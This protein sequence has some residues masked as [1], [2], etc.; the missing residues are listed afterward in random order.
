[1]LTGRG[2]FALVL[3]VGTYV[4][5]WAFGSDALYP[6]AIGLVLVALTAGVWVRLGG[7]P[8]SIKRTVEGGNH[9]SGDDVPVRLDLLLDGRLRLSGLELLERIEGLGER[10]VMLAGKAG[11]VSGR[12]VVERVPRGR[13]PVLGTTAIIEDPFALARRGIPLEAPG[14]LLVYPRLV[15]LDRLFSATGSRIQDGRR[16]L[17]RRPSGF[18]LHSVREHQQGESLRRVHWP[19]TAKRSQLMVKDL[20]DAPRDEVL[21]LLDAEASAVV[22]TPPL[23]SFE[24]AVSAAGSILLAQVR[25]NRRAGLVVNGTETRYQ[26]VQSLEGDW[27]TVLGVLASVQP[28]GRNA[29]AALLAEGAGPVARALD[30]CVVTSALTGRLSERL[31]QR[32]AARRGSSLV[33]VDPAA[34]VPSGKRGDAPSPEA[35]AQI[36]RLLHGGIPVSVIGPDDDLAAKLGAAVAPEE[37]VG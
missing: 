31:L 20:E 9:V 26:P 1:V 5:A 3:G 35:R 36:A 27:D 17:I 25:R 7:R 15:E 11:R 22:G 19:S 37:A 21:V 12:Y 16:L 2:W 14:T 30:V 4:A 18:D 6:V 32:S 8:T 34:F 28:D 24:L 29:V 10:R 23:T 33:Y 13:Y